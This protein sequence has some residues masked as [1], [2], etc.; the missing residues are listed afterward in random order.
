VRKLNC[1]KVLEAYADQDLVVFQA[2]QL[3]DDANDDDDEQL[4]EVGSTH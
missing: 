1:G 4:R 3:A 2:C